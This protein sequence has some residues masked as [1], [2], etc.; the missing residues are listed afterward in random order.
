MNAQAELRDLLGLYALDAL[1]PAD[2]PRV[3]AL[4]ARSPEARAELEDLRLAA[5]ALGS[6]V[7]QIA[8]P[9]GLEAR[10]LERVRQRGR[11]AAPSSPRALTRPSRP[12]L[13]RGGPGRN[14]ARLAFGIA[15]ASLAAVAL[16]TVQVARLGGEAAE[17]VRQRDALLQALADPASR[18]LVLRS[19]DGV[20]QLGQAVIRPDGSVLIVHA[21]GA[22]PKGRVW[23]AWAIRA[24]D[25]APVP[26]ETFAGNSQLVRVPD[27]TVAVAV[28][29]EP[30]GG[31]L[32]PTTVRA[33][34]TI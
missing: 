12:R 23:Q 28:S 33:V 24:D 34:G 29:E 5:A 22:S 10:V 3:E 21:L 20:T 2:L 14:L 9:A 19:P 32:T 11:G 27:G 31:S 7:P 16:L 8:P 26:L 30:A 15:G 1:E 4:L 6:S 18:T 17:A 13:R 25:P